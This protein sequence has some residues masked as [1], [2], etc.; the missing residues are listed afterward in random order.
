MRCQEKIASNAVPGQSLNKIKPFQ[1]EKKNQLVAPWVF[2]ALFFFLKI[3]LKVQVFWKAV[4]LQKA[5]KFQEY[6]TSSWS[7]H[8]AQAMPVSYLCYLPFVRLFLLMQ[9]KQYQQISSVPC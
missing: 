7:L 1:D 3:I 8:W 6:F 9:T 5:P 2:C 4:V